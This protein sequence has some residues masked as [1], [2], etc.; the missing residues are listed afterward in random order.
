MEAGL[1]PVMSSVGIDDDGRLWNI[2]ADDVALAVAL[3]LKAPLIF[4]S[5]V[6]GVLNADKARRAETHRRRH[7]LGRHDRQS[8]RRLGG[9]RLN[10][11]PGRRRQRF[12]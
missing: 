6:R 10:K 4:L 2:N 9:R 5:D 12:R 1:T 11:S 7:H 3:L 8:E